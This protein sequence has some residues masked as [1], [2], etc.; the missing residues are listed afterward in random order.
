MVN[1]VLVDKRNYESV[2]G[3]L[4]LELEEAELIGIDIETSNRN[5]QILFKKKGKDK[6]LDTRRVIVT[7]LSLY[8]EG[9]DNAYYFNLNHADAE[10]RLSWEHV[11]EILALKSEGQHWVAHNAQY[12]IANL[13]AAYGFTFDEIYC[14]MQLCVSAYGPDNYPMSAFSQADLRALYP[15]LPEIKEAFKDFVPGAEMSTA[16]AEVFSKWASINSDAEHSYNGWVDTIAYGYSL[17]KAVKTFFG[18]QM[19]TYAEALQGKQHMCELTGEEVVN[20]GADDAYWCVQLFKRVK[21]KIMA[22][23]PKAWQAYLNQENPMVPLYAELHLH[24]CRIDAAKVKERIAYEQQHAGQTL[25]EIKQILRECLPFPEE[26]N[27]DLMAEEKWYPKGYE[28]YRRQ[29]VDFAFSE[30]PED[31]FSLLEQTNGGVSNTVSRDKKG[32]INLTH[33]MPVRVLLYDL[34]GI[35][36]I[37][38]KGKIGSDKDV[39]GK[40][41]KKLEK[42]SPQHELLLKL[43]HL[44]HIDQCCKLY[45]V[46]YLE[47]LDPDTGK[48]YPRISAQL[49]TRRMSMSD[50]NQQQ[51]SKS[52]DSVYVRGFILPDYDDHVIIGADW[53]SIELVIPAEFSGDPE[54]LRCFN[55]IPYDD[56]HAITAATL[57][58]L[59][60]EAFKSIKKL[61][62]TTAS[63]QGIEFKTRDG[64]FKTPQDFYKYARKEYGK[65]G[66]FNYWFSGALGTVAE[67]LGLSSE[68]MWKLVEKYRALFAVAE[69]WR[70]NTIGFAQ[71]NGYVQLPDGHRRERFEAT[72]LW[73]QLMLEKFKQLGGGAAVLH[74][75]QEFISRWQRRARNQSVNALVQGSAASLAKKSMIRLCQEIGQRWTERQCHFMFPIHDELV[76]SVHRDLALDYTKLIRACMTEHPDDFKRVKLNVAVSMGRNFE[77]FHPVN[78]PQGQIE[79]DEAPQLPFVPAEEVGGSMSADTIVKTVKYLFGEEIA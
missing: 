36:P 39:R 17:K 31:L 57:L 13:K 44:S 77:P 19:T 46:P 5:G 51:M 16:Q 59:T 29:W 70:V 11:R 3:S 41:L 6:I 34:F 60:L 75:G 78:A 35:K 15:L 54:M 38:V 67:R 49:A 73:A 14:S 7:G 47:M 58:G 76:S 55:R 24:G 40:I 66:N 48:L 10:N 74:F 20:Y 22:E 69:A 18:V 4:C 30:N 64:V 37:K 33:Y 52:G 28:K 72:P 43:N 68:E 65:G 25:Q 62:E 61:P 42:G 32:I 56:V 27:E 71:A 1:C 45:L 12:E 21:A 26:P 53:S 8:P 9:A 50:P 79:L 23:N 63:F 2:V